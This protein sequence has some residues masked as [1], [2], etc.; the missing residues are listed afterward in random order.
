MIYDFCLYLQAMAT[1]RPSLNA[2]DEQLENLPAFSI[3]DAAPS[4]DQPVT[5]SYYSIDIMTATD[6]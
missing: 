3:Q 6:T 2:S 1:S 5:V 4:A